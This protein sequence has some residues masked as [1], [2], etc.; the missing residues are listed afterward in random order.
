MY[1]CIYLFLSNLYTQHGSQIHDPKIKSYMF[2]WLN[3]PG[4]SIDFSYVL[5][6]EIIFRLKNIAGTSC[7][8]QNRV[9]ENFWNLINYLQTLWKKEH[10]NKSGSLEVPAWLSL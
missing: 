2:F 9:W 10:V 5:F 8:H 1:V 7:I 3:Q 4:A 6:S